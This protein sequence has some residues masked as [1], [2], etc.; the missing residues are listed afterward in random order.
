MNITDR[1]LNHTEFCIY[2]GI[3][4]NED[5]NRFVWNSI[6][7]EIVVNDPLFL[8]LGYSGLYWIKAKHFRRL[9]SSH[10]PPVTPRFK[11]DQNNLRRN[12]IRLN[13]RDFF[14]ILTRVRRKNARLLVAR[15]MFLA[16]V[17]ILY[18]VYKQ[19]MKL[20]FRT[21][22]DFLE[23]TI[24][25]NKFAIEVESVKNSFVIP[26]KINKPENFSYNSLIILRKKRG[27]R[28]AATFYN[29]Q[30]VTI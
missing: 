2:F 23:H 7:N 30:I 15:Y 3:D 6:C 13:S 16:E 10:Q 18:Q 19:L 5:A 25:I 20:K 27:K 28:T 1:L 17:Y 26:E 22:Q 24:Q 9:M 21:M 14:S 11:R 8:L 29:N 12:Y 4:L